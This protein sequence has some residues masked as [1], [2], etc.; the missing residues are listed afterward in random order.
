VQRES[1]PGGERDTSSYLLGENPIRKRHRKVEVLG[2]GGGGGCSS[3]VLEGGE[4]ESHPICYTVG[5]CSVKVLR[6]QG[7]TRIL[8]DIALVGFW[9]ES[10]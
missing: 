10:S 3:R 6:R 9:G 7:A 1:S 2:G 4:T 8:E 5:F